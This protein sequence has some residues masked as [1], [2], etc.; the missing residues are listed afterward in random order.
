MS[1]WHLGGSLILRDGP[2][3]SIGLW[4]EAAMG[5]LT[6]GEPQRYIRLA[7]PGDSRHARGTAENPEQGD[8]DG[9]STQRR[10]GFEPEDLA[11]I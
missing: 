8:Q 6:R 9:Y 3:I 11:D 4:Y 7:A 10:H 5:A 1:A 2:A